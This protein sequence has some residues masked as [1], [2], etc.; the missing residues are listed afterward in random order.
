MAKAKPESGIL[1]SGVDKDELAEQAIRNA[2]SLKKLVQALGGPERT[3]RAR[4]A[5]AVHEIACR[6]PAVLKPL[7]GDLIDALDRPEVQTRWEI[8]G[9]LEELVAV[10]ARLLDKALEAATV[11][12]HDAESGVVRVAAFRMLAAY[13][14]TTARRAE[15]VWPLLDEAIRAYHGDAEYPAMLAAVVTLVEGAAPDDVR[16]AA[17]DRFEADTTHPRTAISRRAKRVV[18]RAPKGKKPKPAAE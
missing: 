14:A 13:G 17:A 12:L 11:S 18:A 6:E 16:S 9:A 3:E 8:L 5:E 10:D 4:A 2:A 1:K 7:A 15:R